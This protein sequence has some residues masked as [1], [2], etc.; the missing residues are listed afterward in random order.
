MTHTE[1]LKA[2][3]S[4]EF[5][6]DLNRM[7]EE[8]I[9]LF[10]KSLHHLLHSY[11]AGYQLS[12]K[13]FLVLDNSIVQDFKHLEDQRRRP[14]AMAYAAF[15]R[16]VAQWSDLPSYLAVS[17]VALYEHGGR[18]P[19]SSPEHAIDRFIQV[20]TILRYC[21]LPVAMIGFDDGNTLYKRMLDVHADANYLEVF[22]NQIEQ[23][24][25]ERDLRA[26]H[27]GEI[28]AAAW[29]DKAIP[30]DMP[31]RYF[32]PFYIRKVFGSRIEG[33]IADQ[34]EGVV[35][36]QPIRT[37]KIT[38]ALAKLN[39]IT[40]KGV[41]QGLGDIDLLQI[42][43]ISRQ[44]KQPLDHLLLG[45][46]F[47]ADLAKTLRFHH[48]LI[49]SMEV[50]GGAPDVNRQI[51]NMVSFMFSSPFSEHEKRLERIMPLA[52]EFSD[53]VAL[54]CRNA[55]KGRKNSEATH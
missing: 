28:L 12:R 53:H 4:I 27:G 30:E 31:L 42:C 15:C 52:D 20:Q 19:A 23:S 10:Y 51:E 24:E 26:W 16:F 55:V 7:T 37:G 45:Q 14:R 17:P 34:S 40:K 21:G 43:D 2:E 50:V 36:Y 9:L 47:D 54:L 29:A 48:H 39:T 44:Y 18:K 49:E 8:Q 35:N 38:A 33:H 1:R 25:W 22:A 46:T 6:P 5:T 41:L 11:I 32:D 13:I 3:L